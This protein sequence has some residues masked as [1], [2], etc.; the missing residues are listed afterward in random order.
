[1]NSLGLIK[2]ADNQKYKI[3]KQGK[4]IYSLF[5][6]MS[7]SF[8]NIFMD[9]S[10]FFVRLNIKIIIIIKLKFEFSGYNGGKDHYRT[11]LSCNKNMFF[12]KEAPSNDVV[13]TKV[14]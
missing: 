3:T 1:M 10:S 9:D 12:K 7:S 8:I 2:N 6:T 14:G 13:I 5:M 11:C 4:Y